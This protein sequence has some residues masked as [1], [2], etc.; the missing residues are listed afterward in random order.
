MTE[1]NDR[2]DAL[3]IFG[4]LVLIGGVL[5]SLVFET[6]PD[7]NMPL[8][9]ALSSGVLGSGLGAYVGYRWGSSK[10]SAAKDETITQLTQKVPNQ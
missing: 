7:K 1:G 3:V 4:F 10:G 6:I 9:A 5:W 2:L 8:F